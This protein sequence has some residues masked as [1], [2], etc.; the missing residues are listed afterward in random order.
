MYMNHVQ[1][2]GLRG[3]AGDVYLET[4]SSILLAMV[5]FLANQIQTQ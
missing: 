1:K 4:G 3:K 2:V 5:N